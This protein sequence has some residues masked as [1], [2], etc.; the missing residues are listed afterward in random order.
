MKRAGSK[1]KFRGHDPIVVRSP[2][3]DEH[4][5]TIMEGLGP[6]ERAWRQ[7][8]LCQPHRAGLPDALRGSEKAGTVLG[9][10]NLLGKLTDHQHEAGQRFAVIVGRY[11]SSI[12]APTGTH[13]GGKGMGCNP[14]QCDPE[15]CAC[16]SAKQAFAQASRA[17]LDAGHRAQV[18]VWLVTV[19][20]QRYSGYLPLLIRGLNALVRHFGLDTRRSGGK[21]RAFHPVENQ[22]VA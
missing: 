12:G 8:S 4:R 5:D 21:L 1:R 20:D 10:L 14:E 17:L 18:A 6:R 16:L 11:R 22:D 3:T 7:A 13:S 9:R 15:D 2:V 19:H